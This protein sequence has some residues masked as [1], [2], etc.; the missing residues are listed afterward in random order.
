M[1]IDLVQTS[2]NLRE[3]YFRYYDTPFGLAD[4]ELEA[5]RRQ[6]LDRDNGVYREPLVE[7]RPEY[8]TTGHSLQES[9]T[10][11]GA[12]RELADFVETGLI[13]P[14]RQ[15]Y[16]HQEASLISAVKNL[17]NV[18]VT[19]GTGAG[20]T[21]AFLLPLL[22]NLLAESASWSGHGAEPVT[23]WQRAS[24]DFVP[25]RHN[26]TGRTQA[27]RAI[28]LYPMNALVDDQ[29]VRLR[30][31]L[32]SPEARR[33]LDENR[34][35]HRFYFGR[36][37]G[38]TP[39]TG[40][41]DN[42]KARD[43]L[44]TFM[45]GT[46]QRSQAMASD[47]EARYFVPHPGGAEMLSRWDMADAA[48]DILITNYSMLN[49][50]LLRERDSNYFDA[51]REWLRA[52]PS[53][54]FTLVVDE[55]HTYRGTAGTE[56]ALLIR[57]L[58][59][60]LGLDERSDQLQITAAS[61][62]LEENRDEAYVEQFFGVP[63]NTF[64]FLPG[65]LVRPENPGTDLSATAFADTAAIPTR[66]EK[67]AAASALSHAFFLGPGGTTKKKP[68]ARSIEELGKQLF[69]GLGGE[70]GEQAV[71]RVLK[72][73][74]ESTEDGVKWPLLRGHL[75]F[76]NV[77]GMWACTDPDCP[78][79][80]SQPTTDRRIG[81]LYAEPVSRC[82]C[83][84]R[85]LEL[86]YC[87]NCGDVFL[88]GYVPAGATQKPQAN[89][90][91]PNLSDLQ[92]LPDQTTLERTANNYVLYWPQT[93][94]PDLEELEW[95]VDKK[96]VS[97]AFRRS[98]L[99]PLTGEI[100][101]T[102]DDDYTGWTF[103]VETAPGRAGTPGRSPE[104]LSPFPTR[105]PNCSDDW[106]ITH[107]KDGPVPPTD[108][109]RQR[110][111]IRAM[112]TGFEK[113]NQVLITELLQDLQPS[114]R[115]TI[116]FTDSRQDA[117]KLSS[118][119]SL[120][121]YQDLLR[122][123]LQQELSASGQTETDIGLA[124]THFVDRQRSA[125]SRAAVDRLKAKDLH[126]FMLLRDVWEGESD[127]AE[128]DAVQSLL[129]LPSL[130]VLSSKVGHRLLDL[131]MNPGGPA[132]SLQQTSEKAPS[133]WSHLYRWEPNAEEKT[134]LSNAQR[135]L[136]N[137][138]NEALEEEIIQALF[139][140]AGRDFESL[141]LGWIGPLEAKTSLSPTSPEAIAQASL[142]ILADMRRFAGFR[143]ESQKPPARV[144][145]FWKAVAQKYSLDPD[146]IDFSV[147][148]SWGASVR[149][150]LIQPS[151]VT[152]HRPSNAAWTC[153]NCRRQ[154]LV[155]GCGLCT[156][157][158]R[159]LSEETTTPTADPDYYGYNALHAKGQF[160]LN[161]A[162]LTGQTDR[163]DAQ[164][165]QARFQDVFLNESE[166]RKTDG[167]ELLSVTTTMEAGVDIG[168]L[169]SVV[170]ANMPPTR[171]NYQQRVGRAGRRATP[172]AVSL[173]VCRGRSHDEYYFGRPTLITN[174]P[175]P[176]PYLA[177][178]RREIYLRSVHSEVLRRAFVDLKTDIGMDEHIS[179]L[180]NNTHGQ[181]GLLADW[182]RLRPLLASWLEDNAASIEEVARGLASYAPL[183]AG[184]VESVG[185]SIP[186]LLESISHIAASGIPGHTDLSQRLAE[187]GILPMFGFPSKV[188]NLFLQKPSSSFPWPPDNVIDRDA[189]MAVSQFAPGSELVRDGRI[190]PVVGVTSYRPGG[191]SVITEEEPLGEERLVDIC[192]RCAFV[193]KKPSGAESVDTPCPQCGAGYESFGTVD[194]REPQG[195]R[196]GKPRDFDGNFSWSPR[197]TSTRAVADLNSLTAVRVAAMAAYSGPADRYVINDNSGKSFTFQK[198][199]DYWGGYL[200]TSP[201][202]SA[203]DGAPVGRSG[204]LPVD[205][206]VPRVVSAL[207]TIQPTDF[208]FLGPEAPLI[209]SQGLRLDLTSGLAQPHGSI[210]TVEGRRAAWYSLAFLMRTVAAS[211]LD[212]QSQEF[213]AGIFTGQQGEESTTFAFL[214]DSL[215]NGA[216]FSSHLGQPD[217]LP[218]FL[219]KIDK[220]LTELSGE[221]AVDCT[222]SCYRCLCDYS[223]MAYHS[224]LDWRLAKDL[225]G[226]LRGG[227]LAVDRA[228]HEL[229]MGNW[230]SA[231]NVETQPLESVAC[232]VW[233]TKAEGRFGIILRH[234]LEAAEATLMSPRLRRGTEQLT[235]ACPDLDGIVYVDSFA[236]DRDP[237]HVVGL[238]RGMP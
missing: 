162:E 152:I 103:H 17:R 59:M 49:V 98:R 96:R 235:K 93:R 141:G 13:P 151:G 147:R 34:R 35:G 109:K 153:T 119:I 5:E 14:G 115:K 44:R 15:L 68:Q 182:E 57:N 156:Y 83:G 216:G 56:V 33:W 20:K 58:K 123:L 74:T 9:A 157:C 205:P 67:E 81:R 72:A 176:E 32:D 70:E 38:A 138:I 135:D 118:G 89:I 218:K 196:A 193:E 51:T 229:S 219:N 30:K 213:T 64:D 106:E 108:K 77:P 220:Y 79:V 142:R 215:E 29:L 19:A 6:L 166:N 24:G 116:V 131:G 25:Q 66:E 127:T 197:S 76:R 171:F 214:A 101:P 21:E 186:Q 211:H 94:Q 168:A 85:V 50:L 36:Y 191:G 121:H 203:L 126:A 174:A 149:D 8:R 97:Y 233:D 31:A 195:Y 80:S 231:Y 73:S 144:K 139:S 217:E 164:S 92:H 78:E 146:D 169:D 48:P 37:T 132:A 206:S 170:L 167:I 226:I 7:L 192:R 204:G 88:G 155:Y 47:D 128:S 4:R 172:M 185:E 122:L 207:G 133:P 201:D 26:E 110:S 86:L 90:L 183:P 107:T 227:R 71:R 140:G 179:G 27:V 225:I 199:S 60:R 222:S 12:P 189:A 232:A 161:T 100:R 117:A 91:L 208:L 237:S 105:C 82:T 111:P 130:P 112:R 148:Q 124:R 84:S 52:D 75:F 18:V 28:I 23:W 62:S 40:T 194:L 42:P 198:A 175:T 10:A 46:E 236:L 230:A 221:H 43:N 238:L 173:T 160:R 224:L 190:Y 120:R 159:E 181:F 163:L 202:G 187:E 114:N 125:E 113:I 3:S 61:A 143:N 134:Q 95:Q 41:T 228:A 200:S 137:R 129:Q 150:F 11:A 188:R 104:G 55:L 180:G 158:R 209:E 165:R 184:T 54:R 45:R 2:N 65:Q 154:H 87:Q 210:E 234:P 53:H 16:T 136:L 178:N 22:S 39:V 63:R 223:N 145:K 102:A 212:V 1:A 177:L 69:P 99:Q